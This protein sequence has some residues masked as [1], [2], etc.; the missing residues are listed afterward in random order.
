MLLRT[1]RLHSQRNKVRQSSD[2]C[3]DHSILQSELP[4][5]SA[6][7]T[8]G[9]PDAGRRKCYKAALFVRWGSLIPPRY[10][11]NNNFIFSNMTLTGSCMCGGVHYSVEGM[12]LFFTCITHFQIGLIG[13][14]Y[15][16][17]LSICAMPLHGLPKGILNVFL[18]V[19]GM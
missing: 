6:I 13:Y 2:N 10:T 1:S 16:G 17:Q 5:A 7:E 4:S 18:Q 9:R 8:G 11:R 19:E 12:F 3:T 14:S 15:S